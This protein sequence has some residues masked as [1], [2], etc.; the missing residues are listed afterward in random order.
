MYIMMSKTKGEHDSWFQI[1]EKL[2]Y[3]RYYLLPM[4]LKESVLES[5]SK[6]REGRFS[7]QNKEELQINKWSCLN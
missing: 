1:F 2:P 7:V 6:V 5:M 3:E 4:L